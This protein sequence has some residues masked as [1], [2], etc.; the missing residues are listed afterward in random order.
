MSSQ[1][2]KIKPILDAQGKQVGWEMKYGTQKGFGPGDY[3]Q[4][5][6]PKNSGN[7]EFMVTIENANGVAF[8]SGTNR[9][10]DGDN[11]LWVAAGETSPTQKGLHPQ[12]KD[13][14]LHNDTQLIF[15]DSNNGDPVTLAYRLN[16]KNAPSLDPIIVNGGG[17]GPG[18][19]IQDYALY[20]AAALLLVALVAF[21]VRRNRRSRMDASSGGR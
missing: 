2:I 20:G 19:P 6:L 11:A 17:T 13:A 5:V 7:H 4:I 3:P 1:D 9:P 15:K 12:I 21:F 10:K 14:K 16:F 18:I 8:A